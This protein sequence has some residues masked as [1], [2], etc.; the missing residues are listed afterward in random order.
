MKKWKS[1]TTST[2]LIY[3]FN[4]IRSEEP[5]YTYTPKEEKLDLHVD[6]EQNGK[7]SELE[8]VPEKVQEEYL[9]HKFWKTSFFEI[10]DIMDEL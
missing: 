9:Q 5:V 10:D 7:V 3:F 1:R 6:E 2:N 8:K 4:L